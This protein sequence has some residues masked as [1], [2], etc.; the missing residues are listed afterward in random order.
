MKQQKAKQNNKVEIMKANIVEIEQFL[1]FAYLFC[2]LGIFPLHYKEQYYKIGD[3]KFQFFWKSSICF[4]GISLIFV[5]IKTILKE[6]SDT[7]F[8]KE[9]SYVKKYDLN[10]DKIIVEG[11]ETEGE[12]SENIFFK[13]L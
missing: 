12:D 6:I 4:I 9:K 10:K 2:M 13:F 7:G 11:I 5:L 3:A 8:Q 1:T